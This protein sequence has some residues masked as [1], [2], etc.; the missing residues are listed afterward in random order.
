MKWGTDEVKLVD[1][2]V[3]RNNKEEV[4]GAIKRMETGKVQ[5]TYLWRY[6]EVR[7]RGQWTLT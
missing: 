1:Q 3:Q 2:E 5:M 4:R 6:G 7:E